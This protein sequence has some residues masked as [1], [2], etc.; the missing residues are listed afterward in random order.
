MLRL[1]L[2]NEKDLPLVLPSTMEHILPNLL[3]PENRE[4][5]LSWVRQ[6]LEREVQEFMTRLDRAIPS[7]QT[8][9]VRP[10]GQVPLLELQAAPVE[11]QAMLAKKA[12]TPDDD[13]KRHE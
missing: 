2:H 4:L 6:V 9:S 7:R 1:Q 11:V 5:S 13:L 3:D 12:V 8:K 10:S